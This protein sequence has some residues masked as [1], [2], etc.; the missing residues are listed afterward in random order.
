[1]K[2]VRRPEGLPTPI[3]RQGLG[4]GRVELHRPCPS[5]PNQYQR[6]AGGLPVAGLGRG[7]WK[8][9]CT[10]PCRLQRVVLTPTISQAYQLLI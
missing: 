3:D 5:S 1:M 4:L 7:H 9:S 10:L 2:N 6:A 8:S